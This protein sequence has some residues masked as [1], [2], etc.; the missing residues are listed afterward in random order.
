MV[1]PD[2]VL[3]NQKKSAD[4]GSVGSSKETV[5][6]ATVWKT[7][8]NT[9]TNT[10][11]NTDQDVRNQKTPNGGDK[12]EE[13]QNQDQE[14]QQQK[15]QNEDNCKEDPFSLKV[16]NEYVTNAR[17]NSLPPLPVVEEVSDST[18]KS[19]LKKK[20]RPGDAKLQDHQKMCLKT[21]RGEICPF[22]DSC[23]FSHDMKEFLASRPVD[24]NTVEG[25]CPL[26]RLHGHCPFG[27]AC[28]LGGSHLN[29]AT[30]ENL[31]TTPQSP[32]PPPVQNILSKE[33]QTKLR[34]RNYP[35]KC[36]RYDE[37]RDKKQAE[38][39]KDEACSTEEKS[40]EKTLTDLS[41]LPTKRKLIDFSNKV[42]VAPLTTVGNLPFRRIMKRFGADI[43]CGEMALA[44]NLLQGQASEWALLKRHPDEDI[45]GVQLA[46]G[47]PDQFTRIAEV[48]E[49]E[50]EAVDFVDVSRIHAA[51]IRVFSLDISSCLLLWPTTAQS[52]VSSGPALQ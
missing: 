23:K 44:T 20:K 22:G 11:T 35:F 38:N 50:M 16:K 4:A 17:P 1:S 48:I 5:A 12:V 19:K 45:F 34:R 13:R 8:T 3:S 18:G 2:E 32:P 49:A 6:D 42:Y 33:T 43:T 47:Y 15:Q 51:P 24:I 7:S 30:G 26:Y 37:K 46:A 25:G 9:N 52:G 36:K 10:N 14:Q 29:L 31:R 39:K 21:M 27:V 28:R 40:D 41:P